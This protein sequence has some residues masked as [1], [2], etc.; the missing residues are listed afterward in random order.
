[1]APLA[2]LAYLLIPDRDLARLAAALFLGGGLV[3]G[4]LW[5]RRAVNPETAR[6]K[7]RGSQS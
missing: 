6:R 5:E 3:G 2:T 4:L 1:M 7:R